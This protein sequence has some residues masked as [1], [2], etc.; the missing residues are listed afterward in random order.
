MDY[1]G[2]GLMVIGITLACIFAEKGSQ[3]FSLDEIVCLFSQPTFVVY[4]ILCTVTALGLYIFNTH[5]LKIRKLAPMDQ[6]T[7][8]QKLH[9]FHSIAL[10]SLSGIF[11]AQTILLAK[12]VMQLIKVSFDGENQFKTWQPYVMILGVCVAVFGQ[13]HWLA[14]GL[15][16]FDALVMVPFFQVSFILGSVIAGGAYFGEFNGMSQLQKIIFPIGILIV[17]AGVWCLSKHESVHHTPH[18]SCEL[19]NGGI[20]CATGETAEQERMRRRVSKIYTA[21]A[22]LQLVRDPNVSDDDSTE[23]DSKSSFD[24][25]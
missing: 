12:A 16:Y 17:F 23:I 19:A 13:I 25:P 6:N 15:K 18:D 8:Y 24:S 3:C 22:L 2:T 5:C 1:T 9:Q 11:G 20:V 21:N 7:R 10:A 4:A 14:V